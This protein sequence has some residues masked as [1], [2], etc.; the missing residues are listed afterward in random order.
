MAPNRKYIIK[1]T[2]F[3]D[4][5]VV[6]LQEMVKLNAISI[7]GGKNRT[8]INEWVQLLKSALETALPNRDQQE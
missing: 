2:L 3:S 1:V 5:I 6:G 7:F 8:R 4:I